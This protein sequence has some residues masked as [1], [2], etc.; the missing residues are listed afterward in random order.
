[1]PDRP[2][3]PLTAPRVSTGDWP[4]DE[5]AA[6]NR[7]LPVEA[8]APQTP[9]RSSRLPA[10][11]A[12]AA[13]SLPAQLRP[14]PAAPAPQPRRRS[15]PEPG[16]WLAAAAPRAP[17][18]AGTG[19][20]VEVLRRAWPEILQ[21]LTKIK[22]ST[23]A[24]VEPNAQVGHFEDQVLTLAFTTSGLAGAFGRADHSENLRQAIH[25]TI[26]IECQINAVA[27]GS[28]SAASSEPNPK[29][30][31]SRDVPAT[32]A[33]ADWGLAP[34][35]APA[36]TA[37]AQPPRRNRA[38]RL[39]R[40]PHCA[41]TLDP[42]AP[43]AYPSAG[44]S[45]G[46]PPTHPCPAPSAGSGT[47]L[48]PQR[49]AA[50][51]AAASANPEAAEAAGSYAYPDDDWGPPRDEDAPPLDEEPPMDWDPSAP[52]VAR[53]AQPAAAAPARQKGRSG[54]FRAPLPSGPGRCSGPAGAG[55]RQR[56]VGTRRRAG[57][58][59]LDRR[60]GLQR[61]RLP[62]RRS[63][64]APEPAPE[65]EP[66][67]YEPAAAQIPHYAAA[68]SAAAAYEPVA[69]RRTVGELRRVGA[70]WAPL[71]P[72]LGNRCADVAPAQRPV[73]AVGRAAGTRRRPCTP[74]REH[75]GR[76]S[77]YQR[78]SNSPEAEAGRAKAP[79]RRGRHHHLRPGHPERGRRDHRGIGRLRPC[80]RRAYPGR[81][82]G[83]GAVPGRKSAA[84]ALL[85]APPGP[86]P[87]TTPNERGHCVRRC[88]SRADRRARTP[89]RSRA[90]VRP[91]AGLPHPRGRPAGH[92]TARRRHHHRQ[93]TGQV[94]HGLRQRHRA[95]T[96][97]HLPRPSPGPLDHL[98]RRGIQGRPRRGAHP[99]VPGPVP[100]AGRGD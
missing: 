79:A 49:P 89:S 61:R 33:D 20:D 78:L 17:P 50:P 55:H 34:A 19:P 67:H 95:G 80:R 3:K 40:G 97:Q 48:P 81:K 56:P 39:G 59:N 92:E 74:A 26:G 90:Q 45:A 31:A 51:A 82:A 21:T 41:R 30:P 1:M 57:P 84:A 8:P 36:R 24:L 88:S 83:G 2:G 37:P 85:A 66:P 87:V 63:P 11:A 98:R 43:A 47:L 10:A 14:A 68:V 96:L 65:P 46:R 64:A 13:L 86:R 9:R 35:A 73:N 58:R 71:P 53:P 42:A 100:R 12:P 52:T 93:G 4:V 76:Q 28:N 70:G 27:G 94:L 7:R 75:R 44:R 6:V 5:P 62:R 38:C 69:P 54:A 60:H 29:A 15:R 99:L 32:S 72:S 18:A 25:K 91:A 22:R 16:P 23:W 77:L